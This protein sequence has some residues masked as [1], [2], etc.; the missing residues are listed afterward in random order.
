VTVASTIT[1]F[2]GRSPLVAAVLYLAAIGLFVIVSS[3][4]LLDITDQ[5]RTARQ[6]S[7]MLEQLRSREGRAVP[8]QADT[9]ETN[10]FLEGATLN[11]AS[12]AL[13][14]RV[15]GAITGVGG[16]VQSSQ[17]DI[18]T[19]GKDGIVGLLVNFEVEQPA[20][21]KLLFDLETGSP[22]LFIDQ[23]DIQTPQSA[24][25]NNDHASQLRVSL[26]ASGRWRGPK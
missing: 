19:G 6:T 10:P 9:T 1:R 13:L 7:E 26:N 5:M 16:S 25:A 14:Q 3:M 23:I 20:L 24:P 12:A 21:Q 8:V 4:A 17:V 18:T 11:V 15:S 22:L 2:L